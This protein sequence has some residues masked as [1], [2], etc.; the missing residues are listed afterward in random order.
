MSYGVRSLMAFWM[1][2][3]NIPSTPAVPTVKFTG[4]AGLTYLPRK[5]KFDRFRK[6]RPRSRQR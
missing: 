1:G 5:P 3:A 6:W 2:G 4:H